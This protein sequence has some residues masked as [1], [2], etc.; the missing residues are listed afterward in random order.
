MDFQVDLAKA[1]DLATR[2]AELHRQSARAQRPV[3]FFDG[4]VNINEIMS[5]L[6]DCCFFVK[7][8]LTMKFWPWPV[9]RPVLPKS[10]T[11]TLRLD[12]QIWVGSRHLSPGNWKEQN[13][14]LEFSKLESLRVLVIYCHPCCILYNFVIR[15][16][17]RL[18]SGWALEFPLAKITW[19][20][21]RPER[22]G[23][24]VSF[25]GSDRSLISD[26]WLG[27]KKTFSSAVWRW[28]WSSSRRCWLQLLTTRPLS[29]EDLRAATV[30]RCCLEGRYGKAAAGNGGLGNFQG[31]WVRCRIRW[32]RRSK[33]W[34]SKILF[35]VADVIRC[36][37]T[38]I[39]LYSF[40]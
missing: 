36:N 24:G 25:M 1:A 34:R 3:G 30:G 40:V 28:A 17:N 20:C 29:S 38:Y 37:Q 13:F 2:C 22:V 10:V 15:N 19:S 31:W 23:C 5:I 12:T 21:S 26:R 8:T 6:D 27:L 33:I 35:E 14:S 39:S 32:S 9:L 7:F 16:G 4:R 11:M 18:F